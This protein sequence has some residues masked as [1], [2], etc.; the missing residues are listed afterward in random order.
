MDYLAKWPE[1]FPTPEQTTLTIAKLLVEQVISRHGVPVELLSDRGSA[2]LS[3][4]MKEVCQ[5][6]G[7]HRVNTTAY[8]PQTD[9][10]V[11]RFNRTLID[12]LAKRVERNGNDW[13]TQLPY[14]LFAYRASLQESTGESPFFLM[15]GRDPRLPTELLMDSHLFD[16]R[17]TLTLTKVK[18]LPDLKMLGSWPRLM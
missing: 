5:L 7:I 11:E 2:F 18:L 3:H 4:L 12:M 8:H 10:L 15:H 14:V 1:V 13:D 16:T 17:L 9:G 6:L